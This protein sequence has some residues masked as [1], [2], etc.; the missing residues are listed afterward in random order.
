MNFPLMAFDRITAHP[1]TS[2]MVKDLVVHS[3]EEV[4]IL[5]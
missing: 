2:S 1:D 4:V 3:R 5:G